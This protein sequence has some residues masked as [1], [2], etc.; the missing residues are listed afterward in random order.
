MDD[1]EGGTAGGGTEDY[2]ADVAALLIT[3]F[4]VAPPRGHGALVDGAARR[5][6]PAEALVAF[7]AETFDL[8]PLAN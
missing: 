7:L 6:I 2:R 3:Q 8:E 5:G 1:K 4:G